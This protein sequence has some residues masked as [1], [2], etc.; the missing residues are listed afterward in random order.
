[1]TI[2][3]R[4]AIALSLVSLLAP[5]A[6]QADSPLTSTPFHT[7]YGDEPIVVRARG[8]TALDSV[9]I[10]Q[11]RDPSIAND[12]RAAAVNALG[13][14][15]YRGPETSR[16]YAQTF[17]RFLSNEHH[18]R[19]D[20][21]RIEDLTTE[22]LFVL[23]YLAAMDRYRDL[24]PIGGGQGPVQRATPRELLEEAARRMPRDRAIATVVSLVTAQA[25]LER[26]DIGNGERVHRGFCGVWRVYQAS[27]ADG[28]RPQANEIVDSYM[29]AYRSSCRG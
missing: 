3:A 26:R 27:P 17:L 2:T 28:L 14:R 15:D 11:L 23:G 12:V 9:T 29:R 5:L 24:G 16:P 20:Q 7:A 10:H 8:V 19:A 1:M 25:E 13:W 4:V 18:T 21:L 22:D 6:A